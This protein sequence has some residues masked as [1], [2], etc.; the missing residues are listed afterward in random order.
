MTLRSS[1]SD[2]PYNSDDDARII[3]GHCD[4]ITRPATFP[5]NES[6][7]RNELGFFEIH[8]LQMLAFYKSNCIS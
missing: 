7:R 1:I 4:T 3:Q 8:E 6:G 2:V 5:E